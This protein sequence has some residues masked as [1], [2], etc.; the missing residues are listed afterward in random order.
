MMCQWK[1][2]EQYVRASHRGGRVS[3]LDQNVS[4]TVVDVFEAVRTQQNTSVPP[5]HDHHDITHVQDLRRET[6]HT[7]NVQK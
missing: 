6:K 5:R 4:G 1:L 2:T 3:L 7:V